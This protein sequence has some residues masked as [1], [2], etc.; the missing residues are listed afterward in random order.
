MNDFN[1]KTV[2]VFAI[3]ATMSSL[4][5]LVACIAIKA[6]ESTTTQS[7]VVVL[8]WL[9]F[10]LSLEVLITVLLYRPGTKIS[11]WSVITSAILLFVALLLP[12]PFG[13]NAIG[14]VFAYTLSTLICAI[15]ICIFGFG[16]I[17]ARRTEVNE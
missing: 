17:T 4:I 5:V 7:W 11:L 2:A 1:R 15:S 6:F 16:A 9:A 13:G 14:V 12:I 8:S 10:L 3:V